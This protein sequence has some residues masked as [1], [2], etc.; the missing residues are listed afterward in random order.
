MDNE[1]VDGQ[2][3]VQNCLCV[4]CVFEEILSGERGWAKPHFLLGRLE[5]PGGAELSPC[6]VPATAFA[7]GFVSQTFIHLS[8]SLL[9]VEFLTS[10]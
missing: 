2:S 8:A 10:D 4:S 5:V 1:E 7:P 3:R 6:L 9:A